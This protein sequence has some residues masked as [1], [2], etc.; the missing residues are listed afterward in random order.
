MN[1]NK[2]YVCCMDMPHPCMCFTILSPSI[3]IFYLFTDDD[4]VEMC[5]DIWFFCEFY[6]DSG[7]MVLSVFS[8]FA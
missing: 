4:G 8:L 6:V 3:N 2:L 1:E 7:T 5:D